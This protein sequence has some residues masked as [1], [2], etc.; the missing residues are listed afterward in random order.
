MRGNGTPLLRQFYLIVL[1]VLATLVT[2]VFLAVL[3]GAQLTAEGVGKRLLSRAIVVLTDLD[4]ALPDIERSLRASQTDGS[5]PVLV[6]DFPISVEVTPEQARTLQGEALRI[7]LVEEG[8]KRAYEDGLDVLASDPEARREL[9]QISAA[10]AIDRG[11]GIITA[12]THRWL[13]V[14]AVVSGLVA[15]ALCLLLLTSL[16]SW[17][18]R[19]AA[20][21]GVLLG[22]SLPLLA[23]TVAIRFGLSSAQDTDDPFVQGM[24]QIGVDAMAIPLRNYLAL[25]ALGAILLL[26]AMAMVW[27]G[28]RWGEGP[29]PLTGGGDQA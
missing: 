18:G 21:G 15:L 6:P 8:S 14:L 11:L 3:S 16:A 25:S 17:A 24:L 13:V 2:A 9:G 19:L 23:A 12:E 5:G 10:R 4:A 22:S 28:A 27:A 20:L 1:G 7:L 26:L 29:A